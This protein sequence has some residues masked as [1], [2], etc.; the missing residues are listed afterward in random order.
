MAV[1]IKKVLTSHVYTFNG[2]L[3][4]QLLGGAIGLRLTSVIARARMNRWAR[5]VKCSLEKMGLKIWLLVFYVDDVRLICSPIQMGYR[6][7]P[8]RKG[9]SRVWQDGR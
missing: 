9:P 6:W 1:G 3:Y 7:T 5:I 8:G 4:Q 2:R